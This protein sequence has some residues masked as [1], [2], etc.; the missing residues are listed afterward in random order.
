MLRKERRKDAYQGGRDIRARFQERILRKDIMEG[1]I[2]SN[3]G[4]VSRK[5]IREGY[6]GRISRKGIKE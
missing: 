6:Q 5:G 4:S 3:E 1:K 2:S